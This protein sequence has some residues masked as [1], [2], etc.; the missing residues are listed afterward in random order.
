MG[1]SGQEAAGA[2]SGSPAAIFTADT[3]RTDASMQRPLFSRLLGPSLS[4]YPKI[5]RIILVNSRKAAEGVYDGADWAWSSYDIFKVLEAVGGRI[6][7]TGMDNLSKRDGPVVFVANHMSTLETFILPCMIQLRKPVTFVVKRSLITMPF[8]GPIMRSRDPVVVGRENAREDLST[9]LSEGTK[10]LNEGVSIV[11]FPQ[12]TRSVVFRPEEFNTLGIKL[13]L[14]AGVP[15][16]PLALKTD[17]WGAGRIL[18]DFGHLDIRKKVYF[19]FG[20]P[21]KVTGRGAEEHRRII[22]FIREHLALWG[23][24]DG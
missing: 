9:V 17:A 12:S 1:D 18:K 23:N 10:R 24:Q 8:F 14:K 4:F 21:M 11:L 15:V 16:Q 5:F 19:S 7:I 20:E 6:E 3:Y 2:V 22:A 13:A